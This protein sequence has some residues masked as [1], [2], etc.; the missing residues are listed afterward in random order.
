MKVFGEQRKTRELLAPVH[1]LAGKRIGVCLV[2]CVFFCCCFFFFLI[3]ELSRVRTTPF[4]CVKHAKPD[5]K[6]RCHKKH[7]AGEGAGVVCVWKGL[8]TEGS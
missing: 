4:T 7:K 5:S 3:N 1:L 8:S 6:P 2:G